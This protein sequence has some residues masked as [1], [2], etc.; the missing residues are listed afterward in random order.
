MRL[1]VLSFLA[2]G[3]L[4]VVGSGRSD[5]IKKAKLDGVWKLE[6]GERNGEDMTADDLKAC[7]LEVKG[8]SFKIKLADFEG[9]GKMKLDY[10]KTPHT[11]DADMEGGQFFKGIFEMVDENT[12][13]QCYAGAGEDARPTKF[14]T[15]G[16]KGIGQF[17]FVWKREKSAK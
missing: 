1:Y 9:E 2:I 10:D 15:K 8:T 7:Q 4:V 6:K 3:L 14:S 12:L 11:V 13:K 5:D 17:L 16:G